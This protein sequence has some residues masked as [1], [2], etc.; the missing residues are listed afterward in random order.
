MAESRDKGRSRNTIGV[1]F[2]Q[3]LEAEKR[4]DLRTA[5]EKYKMALQLDQ[6]FFDAW[7]N[8]GAIYTRQNRS[9]KAIVC[10]QRALVAKNDVRAHYNLAV[11]YYK[12]GDYANAEKSL[13][14]VLKL[15]ARYLNAHLLLG[16]VFG[17]TGR[18]DKAEISIK[19]A[20]KIDPQNLQAQTALALLYFHTQ[21]F[22]LAARQIQLLLNK[23]PD[24][25]VLLGL[26]AKIALAGD[27]L[28]AASA[29]F[30]K[31]ASRDT[32]LKDFYQALRS[33]VPQ[34]KKKLIR[35]KREKI[36]KQ[37]KKTAK[38][39]LDLSLLQ[40]F[41]GEPQQAFATLERLTAALDKQKSKKN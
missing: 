35:T 23:N 15:D 28:R 1:L 12:K 18:N 41:D 25:K 9:D 8:A 10:Y 27:D 13:R 37:E 34:E 19:N 6:H 26:S 22:D 21:R 40:F 2:E 3:A 33:G 36:E 30:R 39:M 11:E 24:D 32:Q 38:D 14:S 31:L 7:L 29:G 20:L 17:K 4:G 16:Y 5:L